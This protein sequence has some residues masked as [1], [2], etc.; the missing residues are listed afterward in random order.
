MC[1]LLEAIFKLNIK[2]CVCVCVC[3]CMCVCKFH[4]HKMD[5]IT[6]HHITT[7]SITPQTLYNLNSTMLELSSIFYIT[8]HYYSKE[9]FKRNYIF[10]IMK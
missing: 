9:N 8:S 4:C 6:H 10:N 2:E 7:L 5:E 3:M 1:W